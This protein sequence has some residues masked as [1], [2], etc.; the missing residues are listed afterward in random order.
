MNIGDK[1]LKR[2]LPYMHSVAIFVN[3]PEP[4]E[5]IFIPLQDHKAKY[6]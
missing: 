3:H 2:F 5:Q 4:P 1:I 6:E